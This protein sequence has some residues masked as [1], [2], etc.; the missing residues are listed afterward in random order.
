M[1]SFT[2]AKTQFFSIIFSK[3]KEIMI[4]EFRNIRNIYA[5]STCSSVLLFLNKG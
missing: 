2:I 4:R 3:K 5:F 1:S